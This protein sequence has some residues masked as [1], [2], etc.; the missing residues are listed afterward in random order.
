MPGEIRI[1][2]INYFDSAAAVSPAESASLVQPLQAR[3]K[4]SKINNMGSPDFETAYI[5][6]RN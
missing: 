1:G 4:E 5:A 3:K 2:N 6:Y